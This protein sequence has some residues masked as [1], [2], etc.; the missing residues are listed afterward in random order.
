MLPRGT[1]RSIPDSTVRVPRSRRTSDRRTAMSGWEAGGMQQ[2]IG[3]KARRTRS[4]EHTSELQSLMRTSYAV[5]C[6][7]KKKMMALRDELLTH[8]RVEN[9]NN[10]NTHIHK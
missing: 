6:L 7:K 4:E 2:P 1:S 8:T 10:K 9:T 3:R 5:L